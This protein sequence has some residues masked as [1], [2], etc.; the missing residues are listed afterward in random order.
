MPWIANRVR[1]GAPEEI[2]ELAAFL[3]SD[4]ASYLTGS[5]F[6]CDGGMTAAL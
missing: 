4:R 2:G 6:R 5:A 3:C 1:Y